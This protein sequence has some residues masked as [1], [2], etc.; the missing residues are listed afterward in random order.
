MVTLLLF[1]LRVDTQL[2]PGAQHTHSGPGRRQGGG[3]SAI[4]RQE[5]RVILGSLAHLPRQPERAGRA[6]ICPRTDR[7][8]PC[9]LAQPESGSR[10]SEEARL[11]NEGP[12]PLPL[13]LS[14]D[15]GR[16]LVVS[17]THLLGRL[18]QLDTLL[19]HEA[20]LQAERSCSR[21]TTSAGSRWEKQPLVAWMLSSLDFFVWRWSGLGASATSNFRASGDR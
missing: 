11:R 17:H 20:G 7:G 6:E 1:H 2:L 13:P 5:P 3:P 15:P 21:Q 16:S 19:G 14:Q 18:E 4:Q 9:G 12:P 10:A 8:F